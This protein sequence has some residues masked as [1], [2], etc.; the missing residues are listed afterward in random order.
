MKSN[1]NDEHDDHA[2]HWGAF[3]GEKLVASARMCVHP[4]LADV[5]DAYMFEDFDLPT[6][7]AD[8]NRLVVSSAV[9]HRGLAAQFDQ[10]RISEARNLECRSIVAVPVDDGKRPQHLRGL[11]FSETGIRKTVP[12]GDTPNIAMYLIL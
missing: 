6:P 1:L 7:V 10:L 5:P 12:W 9:R 4:N 3:I 11:G 8:F 2:L